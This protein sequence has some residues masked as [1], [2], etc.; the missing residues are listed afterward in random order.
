MTQ[1]RDCL[2]RYIKIKHKNKTCYWEMMNYYGSIINHEI[3]TWFVKLIHKNKTWYEK[4]WN[5]T[6]MSYAFSYVCFCCCL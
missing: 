6:E 1:K 2:Y 3:K 4:T 5:T